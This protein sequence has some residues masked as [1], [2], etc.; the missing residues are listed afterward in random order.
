MDE[1]G[2]FEV[3]VDRAKSLAGI[4]TANLIAYEKPFSLSSFFRFMGKTNAENKV[5]V[6]IGLD[7]CRL[8]PYFLHLFCP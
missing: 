6:D 1:L 5:K 8:S 2:S 7:L 4:E 3:A